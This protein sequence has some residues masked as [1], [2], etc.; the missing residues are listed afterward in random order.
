MKCDK[1]ELAVQIYELYLVLRN[2]FYF[3]VVNVNK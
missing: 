1:S 3:N 2:F